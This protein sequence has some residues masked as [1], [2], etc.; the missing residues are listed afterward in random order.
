MATPC[1]PGVRGI[2]AN[3]VYAGA[4]AFGRTQVQSEYHDGQPTR[5]IRRRPR[6]KWLALIPHHHP[7]YIDW[8]EFERIQQMLSQNIILPQGASPGAAKRGPALLVGLLRADVVDA[9]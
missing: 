6:E 7:G 5:L 4:Y 2:L 9:S 1:L 8:D 3:P